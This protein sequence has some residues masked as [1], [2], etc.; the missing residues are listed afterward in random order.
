M[1]FKLVAEASTTELHAD[2]A[3]GN[4]NHPTET[5]ETAGVETSEEAGQHA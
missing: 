5:A 1:P 3:G 4:G 2:K